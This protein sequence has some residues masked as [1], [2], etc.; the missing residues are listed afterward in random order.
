MFLIKKTISCGKQ[1]KEDTLMPKDTTSQF[2]SRL[3]QES[4]LT[5]EEYLREGARKM[6]QKAIEDEVNDYLVRHRSL[7]DGGRLIVVRNGKGRSRL[8]QT[9]IGNIEIRQ[10]RVLDRRRGRRFTSGILPPYLRRVPTLEALLPVLYLKGISGNDFSAALSDIL[11]HDAIG[12]SSS[13]IMRLKECW[14]GEYED[15]NNRDL[16]GKRYVYF[17]AD[18]IY[19]NVRLTPER[20]CLLVIIGTLEDGTKELVA[21]VD[22][23]RESTISWKEVLLDLKRRG[24]KKA[25]KLAVG[26]G[27]LGFWAALEEVFPETRIQRC[28]VHKTAN[29]LDK[30]PKKIQPSAKNLIHEMYMADTKENALNAYSD[31]IELYQDKYPKAVQ[32]LTKDN[33]NLFAFYDFPAA[34]WIHIRTT[35]PIESTFATVRHRHRQTKGCGSIKATI[36]M[37]FKLSK[38]AEIRWRKIKGYELIIKVLTGVKFIDG[39]EEK[40]A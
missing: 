4:L 9:G 17:W 38:E 18:G 5:L 22:G 16:S 11:G 34:H 29:I 12:L 32:C 26:D 25:P 27:A 13:S 40:A 35:N 15:W 36:S 10:P 14:Q 3:A 23:V 37:A 6:L 1:E 30:L 39:I 21:M 19:F 33:D 20:P 2:G 24:L 8:L 31:F 7:Q 28:W